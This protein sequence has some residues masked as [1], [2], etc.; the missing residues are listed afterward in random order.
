MRFSDN[1]ELTAANMASSDILVGTDVSTGDDKK[2]TLDGLGDWLTANKAIAKPASPT[3]GQY[4]MWNGS[5]W[6]AQT[7]PVYNGGVS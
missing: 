7:L 1:S 6:V 2:F 5:A 4:L 3:S